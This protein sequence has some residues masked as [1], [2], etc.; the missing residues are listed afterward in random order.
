MSAATSFGDW[1]RR[2]RKA[3]D[4]LQKELADR[5]GCSLTAL[6]KIERDERRPSRQLAERLAVC[7]DVPAAERERF[8]RVA[9]GERPVEQT[10]PHDA[11]PQVTG[12]RPAPLPV[13][14]SPLF[15]RDRELTQ[16]ARLVDDRDCRLLTLTGPGGIG[17]TRLANEVAL[18]HSPAF[19]QGAAFIRLDALANRE[20]VVTAVADTLGLVLYSAS[21]RAEQLILALREREMLLVLDNFEHLLAEPGCVTLVGDLVREVPGVMLLATSREPLQ[22]QAEWIFAVQG[23]PT[24]ENTLP[25]ALEASS[26]ARLFL[27][28][29]RQA[30]GEAPLSDGERE[31]VAQICQLVDGLPLGIEL[32][33]AWATT[34]SCEE[35]ARELQQSL[36]FLVAQARDLPERHRSIQ[37]VFEHSW[38]LL[39]GSEQDALRRMAIFRGGFT[40]EAAAEVAGTTLPVLSSLVAKS[41]LRR[42]GPARYEM[43]ELVRQYARERLEAEPALFA[44]TARR[45]AAAYARLLEQRGLGLRGPEQPQVIAELVQELGNIRGAWDW[46]VAHRGAEQ[47]IQASDTLFW[48]YEARSNCRE[49]VPLFG[50]AIQGLQPPAG[51]ALSLADGTAA[52]ALGQALS[53]QGY[54]CLRQG[55]HRLARDLLRQSYTLLGSVED[56]EARAALATAGA[57]LGAATYITGEYDEGRRLLGASLATTRAAGDTWVAAFCLRQLGLL[58]AYIGEHDEGRRLLGESLALSREMGNLW[59][60]ASSL[61][62]L[63]AA[64]H[65]AGDDAAAAELLDEALELSRALDDRFNV[66]SALRG[67]GLV[68][69]GLNQLDDARRLLEDSVRLWREIGDQESLARTLNQLGE[70]LLAQGNL[71]EARTCFLD[72]LRVVRDAQLAP[73]LL[74]ALLGLAAVHV[75]EGRP[76]PA[77]A[78]LLPVL[79]HPASIEQARVRADRLLVELAGRVLPARLQTIAARSGAT[80]LDT[81]VRDLLASTQATAGEQRAS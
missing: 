20:Q 5:A 35:I 61:N 67:L 16:I 57:F 14:Q 75:A 79:Q 60:I 80:P 64:A 47:L 23:L 72:A 3:L 45:H 25:E 63:G 6:Q 27:Q 46:A 10:P 30:R 15:G 66:A 13:P 62:L 74:E 7:L 52:L 42:S 18:Q 2:R 70:L 22:L 11:P 43:H 19:T 51:T 48:L 17:K 76:E 58:A 21:D 50:Q 24:P 49:G 54:F 36:S 12:H 37:A 77:L 68:R 8:V 44:E 34:L 39:S 28:R 55:Q 40:R 9:R 53:Y 65:I 78:L 33:A 59:S 1:V 31:A 26:A 69:W 32:A 81:L 56:E 41:L 71:P 29:A 73:I 4:L 38:R